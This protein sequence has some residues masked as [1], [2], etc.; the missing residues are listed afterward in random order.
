M[1]TKW[2]FSWFLS[3]DWFDS[4]W[5]E[6]DYLN[7]VKPIYKLGDFW[8]R[9]LNVSESVIGMKFAEGYI[10]RLRSWNEKSSVW[11]AKYSTIL[12]DS[13]IKSFY[14]RKAFQMTVAFVRNEYKKTPLLNFKRSF[15]LNL[16]IHITKQALCSLMT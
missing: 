12:I 1:F 13:D 2:A 4:N 10:F 14:S 11:H 5:K 8:G 16:L 15:L 7:S 3:F 9:K 6:L